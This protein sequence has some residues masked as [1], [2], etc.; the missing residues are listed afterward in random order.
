MARLPPS[1]QQ[2]FSLLEGLIAITIFSIGLLGIVSLQANAIKL[3]T[4]SKYRADAAFLA[5]QLI[6]QLTVADP[7]QLANYAHRS[8]GAACNPS[9]A[10]STQPAVTGWLTQVTQTLP[11]APASKQQVWVDPL[12]NNVVA[13]TIC[14]QAPQ[15]TAPHSHTV[16]TQ[17]QW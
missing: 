16:T 14:W 5:N 3:S 2:G 7:A 13:V 1:R 10:S 4:D 9:G 6:G 17:L 8:S 12:N 15:E 11:N